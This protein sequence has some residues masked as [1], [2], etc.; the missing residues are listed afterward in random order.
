MLSFSYSNSSMLGSAFSSSPR[1]AFSF[2][3]G[4]CAPPSVV[5][6]VVEHA[7]AHTAGPTRG[8]AVTKSSRL[9]WMVAC[10]AVYR[11]AVRST[12]DAGVCSSTDGGVWLVCA[13]GAGVA[14]GAGSLAVG[15]GCLALIGSSTSGCCRLR[16]SRRGDGG[17]GGGGS[18]CHIL[19]QQS[20]P[21]VA[22][23]HGSVGH[24][25]TQVTSLS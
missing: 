7:S 16:P 22:T 12:C 11:R 10:D 18:T 2:L 3:L 5:P 1:S 14:V 4:W 9:R 23:L 17:G 25:A 15:S 20:S 8:V 6:S 21:Q 24:H 13:M 19:M